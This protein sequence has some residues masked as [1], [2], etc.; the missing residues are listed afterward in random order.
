MRVLACCIAAC[1]ALGACG[2]ASQ[3]SGVAPSPSF[4]LFE[5]E[6]YPQL[7]RDCAFSDCHGKQQRF[8]QVYGP[9]RTR[10]LETSMPSDPATPDEI[11]RSYERARS[12]LAGTARPED[13]LLLRKP[14]ETSEGGQAHKG[15]DALGRN[16]YRYRQDPSYALLL[17]WAQSER[18]NDTA[19]GAG[20]AG[21]NG[22]GTAGM[23]ATP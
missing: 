15:L 13:A 14:L 10:L 8:F 7:L 11:M 12:M 9:G 16:V 22:V 17:R 19:G 20:V 5:Q 18:A 21:A 4:T 3:G 6:V 1:A 2:N 23:G